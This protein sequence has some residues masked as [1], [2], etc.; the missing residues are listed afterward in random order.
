MPLFLACRAG[1]L[2]EILLKVLYIARIR[3][4][5]STASQTQTKLLQV[6]DAHGAISGLM[7]RLKT[8]KAKEVGTVRFLVSI[9]ATEKARFF[10]LLFRAMLGQVPGSSALEATDGR[11]FGWIEVSRCPEQPAHLL[12]GLSPIFDRGGSGFF[13][14]DVDLRTDFDPSRIA[15]RP[16]EDVV[17]SRFLPQLP[18]LLAP[19]SFRSSDATRVARRARHGRSETVGLALIDAPTTTSVGMVRP[20]PSTDDGG[21]TTGS[22]RMGIHGFG[23]PWGERNEH[24]TPLR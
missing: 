17:S 22:E 4:F 6:S 13:R 16:S 11:I 19:F 18:F 10:L 1:Y 7:S 12:V 2:H 20:F 9:L 24:R 21:P 15:F 5:A 14:K 23:F 3:A 8:S